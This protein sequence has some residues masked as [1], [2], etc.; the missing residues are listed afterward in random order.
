MSYML[1][2]EYYHVLCPLT[3]YY[4]VLCPLHWIFSCPMSPVLNIIMS[5]VPCTEY[6]HVLCPLYWI[7]SCPVYSVLNIINIVVLCPLY[8]ILSCEYYRVLCP[9]YWILSCPMSS[10]LNIVMDSSYTSQ[11]GSL[12]LKPYCVTI[13]VRCEMRKA[14]ICSFILLG[15]CSIPRGWSW[16]FAL[17]GFCHCIIVQYFVNL[18]IF[19]CKLMC[20]KYN[21]R[22]CPMV[23]SLRLAIASDSNSLN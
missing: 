19:L 21:K 15:I 23:N 16:Y 12:N 14:V 4:R 10:L 3:E 20:L 22:K 18:A 5:Y 8:W 17:P 13:G 1:C 9:L 6:Y 7:L 2:T 11:P